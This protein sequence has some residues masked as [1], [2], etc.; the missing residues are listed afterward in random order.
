MKRSLFAIA[1]SI[2]FFSGFCLAAA[3]GSSQHRKI[4]IVSPRALNDA[5]AVLERT[6]HCAI[7]FEDAPYYNDSRSEPLW[8][9]AP[10]MAKERKFVFEYD[11]QE[12]T[13]KIIKSLLATYYKI[14]ASAVFTVL[15]DD[16]Q[17]PRFHI[18]PVKAMA[19]D[20]RMLPYKSRF[21]SAQTFQLISG[22]A[23]DVSLAR[24]CKQLST[25]NE[26]VVCSGRILS[27]QCERDVTLLATN[28]LSCM[29]Q[30][31]QYYDRSPSGLTLSWSIRRGPKMEKLNDFCVLSLRQMQSEQTLMQDG[32]N[33]VYVLVEAARPLSEA[34]RIL[35]KM[36]DCNVVYE[37]IEYKCSCDTLGDKDGHLQVPRG[38][39]VDFSFSSKAD[40]CQVVSDCVNAYNYGQNK[41]NEERI[42]AGEYS[43]ECR[44]TGPTILVSPSHSKD[45]TGTMQRAEPL[46]ATQV[47]FVS[48]N[49]SV[50]S[51]L[52]ELSSAVTAATGKKI[53]VG[54]VPDM[55]AVLP[56]FTAKGS[57]GEALSDLMQR[58]SPRFSCYLIFEPK[59]QLFRL[60]VYKRPGK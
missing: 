16:G 19:K 13:L 4:I 55:E 10:R 50:M 18:Y 6:I 29:E 21:L 27:P 1:I 35:D 22:E 43:I 2:L 17:P 3:L 5:V 26:E 45:K 58:V 38:G 54:N 56:S 48:S 31:L 51:I 60:D 11:Q 24:L 8:A 34:L 40:S 30:T 41:V 49:K 14:D 20:G 28:G 36:I 47:S 12:D 57:A 52:Q 23:L 46:L 33:D 37:D 39:I 25:S 44:N 7:T 53:V 9:G 15:K 42:N 59:D 32:T